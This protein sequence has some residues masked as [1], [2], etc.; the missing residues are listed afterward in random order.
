MEKLTMKRVMAALLAFIMLT[1]LMPWSEVRGYNPDTY[2]VT[3][4]KVFAVYDSGRSFKECKISLRGT[5]LDGAKVYMETASGYKELTNRDVNTDLVLQFSVSQDMLGNSLLIGGTVIPINAG[6]MPKLTGVSGKVRLGTD[7]LTLYGENLTRI[8]DADIKAKYVNKL[9]EIEFG[10]L[11][12]PPLSIAPNGKTATLNTPSGEPG[13][14]DIVFEKNLNLTGI[15]FN[16]AN[17]DVTVSVSVKYTYLEQFRLVKDIT[18]TNLQM[19][20]NT[21][22]KGDTVFFEAAANTLDSYDVFFIKKIDGTDPYTNANKGTN[23]TFQQNFGGKDVLAV[24]VPN[25]TVGEYYVVLTNPIPEGQNPMTQVFQELVVGTAPFYEKFI[26]VDGS[27]KPKILAVEPGTGPDSGSKVTILG[28]LLASINMPEFLPSNPNIINI[29]SPLTDPNPRELKISYSPGSY[30]GVPVTS[31]ERTVKVLIGGEATFLTN[32]AGTNYDVL[33]SKDLDRFTVQTPQVTDA[34]ANPKKDVV[35]EIETTFTKADNS[36]I[37]IKERAVLGQGYTYIPSKITPT[38]TD[39]TPDKIQI[40]PDGNGGFV[41]PQDMMIA[42][43]GTNLMVHKFVNSSGKEITRYPIVEIGTL[44][45]N[46]NETVNPGDPVSSSAISIKVFNAAGKELDGTSGNEIGTRILVTIPKGTV[47]PGLTSL[48]NGK[49]KVNLKVSNPVRNSE[50]TGIYALKAD[51]IELVLPEDN[52]KP[53]ITSVTPN[54]TTI[55]GG[56]TIIIEGSNFADGIKVFLDGE[57]VAGVTRQGDGKKLTFVCPKGRE[58][59]TQLLVMNPEGGMDTWPFTFVKAFTNPKL[60]DFLPKRGNTGT[61]VVATGDNFLKPD[62]TAS[63]KD[64]YRLIGTRVLLEGKD[65]NQYNLNAVTKRVELRD[66]DIPGNRE[67]VYI[68]GGAITAFSQIDAL[69]LENQSSQRYYTLELNGKG[70]YVLSNGAGSTY[71]LQLNGAGNAIQASK[72][73]GSVFSL[74]ADAVNDTITIGETPSITLKVRTFYADVQNKDGHTVLGKRVKV[75]DRTRLYFEVPILDADGYY[76]VTVMNPDTKKDSKLDQQGF[77]YYTQPQTNPQITS[78]EPPE[79]S[80]DGGYTITLNGNDFEDNGTSK[81]KVYING[82]EAAPQDVAVSTN[83]KSIEV[84]VPKYP[85]DLVQTT[86]GNR[87]TVPVVVVNPDGASASKL[88]G[89]T[90]VVPGSY[91]KISKIVPATGSASGGKIVEITGS[92]F[93]F[94]EPYADT[95]RNGKWDSG[96]PYTDINGNNEWDGPNLPAFEYDPDITGVK[97]TVDVNGQ[98]YSYYASP[99]MPKVYFG[100]ARAK[101]IEFSKG[102]LKVLTP[103]GKAGPVQVFVVNNDAGVSNRVNYTYVASKP[104]ISKILPNEGKKQGKDKLDILGTNFEQSKVEVYQSIDGSGNGIVTPKTMPLVRFGTISNRQIPRDQENSGRIDNGRA[105][106]VLEGGLKVEYDASGASKSLRITVEDKGTYQ[107]TINQYDD[108]VKYIDLALLR[109]ENSQYSGYELVR[110]EVADRRL[111]V[112]RGYSPQAQLINPNQ[113]SVHS[114]SY[115]TIGTVSVTAVNPDGG[116]ATGSFTYKNPASDPKIINITKENQPPA[117]G[118]D[119]ANDI[120]VLRMSIRGGSIVSI[121]GEDFRERA[122]IQVS[123]VVDLRADKITYSLP[124]KLTF[125]MPAVPDS[126]LG[127][128]HRVVVLNEDGGS[129]ASDELTPPIYIIF[130]KG[131]TA[132]SVKKLTPNTG[133]ATGGTRVKIEGADFR[134]RMEGYR[135]RLSVYF[136]AYKVPDSEVTVVDYKTIFANAPSNVPGKVKIRVENPDGEVSASAVEFT[137]LSCPKILTVVDP[138]DPSENTRI[139]SVSV[140]GGQELKLKGSGFM[141]GARVVFNPVIKRADPNA[142]GTIININGAAYLLESG[143]DGTGFKFIDNETVTI[144]APKGK[145]GTRGIIVINPDTGASEVYG[146]IAYGLPELAAP[147]GVRAELVYDRY[148]KISW[149][150]VGG[151]KEYEIYAIINGSGMELIGSTELNSYMFTGIE[152]RTSYRFIIKAIADYGPSNPSAESN[153]V[154]TGA[155]AG[156]PDDDGGLNDKTTMVKSGYS[157]IVVIG[158]KDFSDKEI[159]IDLTSGM[160]SGSKEVTV[161]IPAYV[162]ASASARNITII[163]S[164]FTIKFNPFAFKSSKMEENRNR[165]DAGVRFKVAPYNEGTDTKAGEVPLSTQYNLELTMFVGKDN[166]K[167]E[168]L[169]SNIEMVMDFDTYKA[170]MRGYQT[171][172]LSRYEGY[173]DGWMQTGQAASSSGF[174]RAYVNKLGRYMVI[175]RRR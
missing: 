90:Y 130:T 171:A 162:I 95:N 36:K 166:S 11:G 74:T 72:E 65:V 169:N 20:P 68:T 150:A 126:A 105:T 38:I 30:D 25:L 133:P 81:T 140:E 49:A 98:T 128:L 167:M 108:S 135:G 3:E 114:A 82:I 144:I 5:S 91:P 34:E 67:L 174:V 76:D 129:A 102:Y 53:V 27:R 106:V 51:Y 26:V 58:G 147:T 146:D 142:K 79:G 44:G 156:M 112:D 63:P 16:P 101:I 151:A 153:T 99:A 115:Y 155:N 148:I 1:C 47:I 96:E 37:I 78:I 33:P 62:P 35:I 88:D 93:R 73:G 71:V 12:N 69:V 83:G 86:G 4:V 139:S 131:D 45:L 149:N 116:T 48:T 121:V 89:F 80:V 111:I 161:S 40:E 152:P 97:A 24:R 77:Y 22:E 60:T 39:A 159:T 119:G 143:T 117:D 7:N 46:V 6:D 164:D 41:L 158:R 19:H 56:E 94:Y 123:D 134:E 120:K 29:E 170:G 32:P 125:E 84:K 103:Q 17:P 21:G 70:Q 42:I 92:D 14:Q 2:K 165:R 9:G 61:L 75:I 145:V 28:Q 55:D 132:P 136:G 87:H 172:S 110:V 15:S 100:S 13:F 163:G 124:N 168:H 109:D 122:R 138:A 31:A 64:V 137:Y 154:T 43:H 157:A 23:K 141:A 59:D 52:K 173:G 160:L 57:P 113:L 118:K 18:A 85:G 104:T 175:G 54:V 10:Q 50:N 8:D 66:Y 127:K 107:A